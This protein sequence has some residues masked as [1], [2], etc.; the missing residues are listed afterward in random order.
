MNE[1]NA[2][3]GLLLGLNDSW[4]MVEVNV[5]P[6]GRLV[7][8]QF[9]HRGG[10]LVCPDCHQG[11]PQAALAAE[12]TWRYLDLTQFETRVRARVSRCDCEQCGVKTTAVPWVGKHARFTLLFE[13]FG[14]K[15]F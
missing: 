7:E 3:Y 11:W 1:L 15:V 6:E 2:H 4:E 13:T 12:R 8:I 10:K 14:I 9:R 5:D